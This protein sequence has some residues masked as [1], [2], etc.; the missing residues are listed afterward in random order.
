MVTKYKNT[1]VIIDGVRYRSKREAA[2]H[3]TL[4]QYEKAGHISGLHREVPFDLA[5]GVKFTGNKKAKP[6]LRYFADFVYIDSAG[7]MVVED[8]KGVRT[9]VYKIKRHLMLSE[10]GIEV[11]ET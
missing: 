7:G 4:L 9:A 2:R 5:R 8:C 10:Y 3:Q 11:L 1:P 6:A